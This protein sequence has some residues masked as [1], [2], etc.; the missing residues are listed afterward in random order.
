V[1]LLHDREA[2]ADV[3]RARAPVLAVAERRGSFR[4]IELGLAPE[5]AEE[6]ARR[7]LRCDLD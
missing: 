4:E 1:P 7:C 5:V 2:Y 3:V 6:E